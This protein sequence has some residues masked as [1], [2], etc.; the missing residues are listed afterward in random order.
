MGRLEQSWGRD[1]NRSRGETYQEALRAWITGYKNPN[2]RRSY[3][4]SL[5]EFFE[6]YEARHGRI[7]APHEVKQADASEYARWLE[8]HVPTPQASRKAA[9][10]DLGEWRL[11]QAHRKLDLAIYKILLAHPGQTI[12]QIRKEL[13][14]KYASDAEVKHV[15]ITDEQGQKKTQLVLGIEASAPDDPTNPEDCPRSEVFER[16]MARLVERKLLTRSPSIDFIRRTEDPRAGI[17]ERVDPSRFTYYVSAHTA[18]T[19]NQR[20]GTIRTRIAALMAFWTHLL[21]RG[22]NEGYQRPIEFNIWKK[23]FKVFAK[24]AQTQAKTSRVKKLP[25]E[26]IFGKLLAACP[27][28]TLSDIRDRAMLLMLRDTGVRASEL[29]G[30]VRSDVQWSDDPTNPPLI[31]I[32]GKGDKDRTIVFP[33]EPYNAIKYLEIKLGELAILGE[34]AQARAGGGAQER[35][36]AERLLDATAPLFPSIR[37]WGCNS[38]VPLDKPM[39]R[40]AI[41]MMLRRRAHA[42]GIDAEGTDFPRVHPHGF[43]HLAA[44]LAVGRGKP[45]PVIMGVLGHSNLSTTSTYVEEFSLASLNLTDDKEC[46][47]EQAPEIRYYQAPPGAA[48][49]GQAP[50]GAPQSRYYEPPGKPGEKKTITAYAESVEE[51][52]PATAVVAPAIVTQ[53]RGAAAEQLAVVQPAPAHQERQRLAR[54]GPPEPVPMGQRLEQIGAPTAPKIVPGQP[55][56]DVAYRVKPG[57]KGGEGWQKIHDH[58]QGGKGY[59]AEEDELTDTYVANN[60]RLLWWTGPGNRLGASITAREKEIANATGVALVP[61]TGPMPVMATLQIEQSSHVTAKSTYGTVL[62]GLME[63]WEKWIA[64]DSEEQGPFGLLESGASATS[65]LLMWLL[66]AFEVTDQV[67]VHMKDKG[68]EWVPYDMPI[69][70]SGASGY[71]LR[72][73]REHREDRIVR[74]FAENGW[75]YRSTMSAGEAESIYGNKGKSSLSRLTRALT[76]PLSVPPWYLAADPLKELP[77]AERSDLLDWVAALV[78]RPP[79]DKTPRYRFGVSREQ[80]GSLLGLFSA[81]DGQL[82][83]AMGRARGGGEGSQLGPEQRREAQAY[84][85]VT[86]DEIRELVSRM[87]NRQIQGF[88]E[89]YRELLKIRRK[90]TEAEK[91]GAL[92]SERDESGKKLTRGEKR[93]ARKTAREASEELFKAEKARVVAEMKAGAISREQAEDL[94]APLILKHADDMKRLESQD[95]EKTR[96]Y[97]AGFYMKVLADLLGETVSQ[98]FILPVFARTAAGAPLRDFQDLLAPNA[99]AQTIVHTEQFAKSWAKKH[100]THSECVARRTA[101]DL[102]EMRRLRLDPPPGM[103]KPKARAKKR[104]EGTSDP[105]WAA[106][107]AAAEK[108]WADK[109]ASQPR[110]KTAAELARLVG[111]MSEYRIPCPK[112]MESQLVTWLGPEDASGRPLIERWWQK[113]NELAGGEERARERQLALKKGASRPAFSYPD[114]RDVQFEEDVAAGVAREL[115]SQARARF[116]SPTGIVGPEEEHQ[117]YIERM[118]TKGSAGET[119]AAAARSEAR[120]ESTPERSRGGGPVAPGF[121]GGATTGTDYEAILAAEG[122]SEELPDEDGEYIPNARVIHSFMMRDEYVPNARTRAAMPSPILLLACSQRY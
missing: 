51:G 109:E 34:A 41:A 9:D 96:S 38:S 58:K 47:P 120:R 87:T 56:P 112:E 24:I 72:D 103:P 113:L 90:S 104:P 108:S 101:R 54:P 69:S 21:E 67:R 66:S 84:A 30:L 89:K 83:E 23:E 92:V 76:T 85:E 115:E 59:T 63:L 20:A 37:R 114:D 99:K 97:R 11:V 65:A 45:L 42:A 119:G 64:L 7:P 52:V 29:G 79:M 4:Y 27:R 5:I 86:S 12:S 15:T 16:H 77:P 48:P 55:A 93:V 31:T 19:G 57:A 95:A 94:I 78:G 43:R 8:T 61:F 17:G 110:E 100:R 88:D 102:W 18:S 39:S 36:R 81:L 50:P 122:M 44:R 117:E 3:G 2:T 60:S 75:H 32:H 106:I 53:R 49:A 73:Y 71:S 33:R 68:L 22:E 121:T 105:E 70:A 6:W 74:W 91:A 26:D 25:T 80:A 62:N 46:P 107:Q 111:A 35:V 98:D 118:A 1:P 28:S 40:Q 10:V 13:F 14:D 82:D 116:A